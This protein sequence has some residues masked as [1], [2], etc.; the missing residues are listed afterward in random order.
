MN[1]T[2]YIDALKAHDWDF[3]FSDAMRTYERGMDQYKA[4]KAAA[5]ERGYCGPTSHRKIAENLEDARA[6]WLKWF[7]LKE[8]NATWFHLKLDAL[9]E[10]A[11]F[12][13]FRQTLKSVKMYR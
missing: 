13:Y 10:K 12:E 9:L 11:K 1:M 8:S 7:S 6:A 4:L 5:K 3:R 2:Q